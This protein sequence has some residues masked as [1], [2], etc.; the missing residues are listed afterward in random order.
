M[1]EV[2]VTKAVKANE[3]R[4]SRTE[5]TNSVALRGRKFLKTVKGALC[6]GGSLNPMQGGGEADNW[7]QQIKE[8][9]ETATQMQPA[10]QLMER[11]EELQA[12]LAQQ[13]EQQQVCHRHVFSMSRCR[14]TLAPCCSECDTCQTCRAF[15]DV[16]SFDTQY[17]LH[18]HANLYTLASPT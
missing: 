1:I 2:E 4:Q 11:V 9:L 10:R 18:T 16:I 17:V 8:H 3:R 13:E 7:L 14:A 5:S 12:R 15:D 6:C